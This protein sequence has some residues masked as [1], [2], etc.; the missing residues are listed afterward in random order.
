MNK[1][2]GF[3]FNTENVESSEK[4]LQAAERVSD[5]TMD[6]RDVN[7]TDTPANQTRL[8]TLLA[9]Q[10]K[11]ER[12]KRKQ[13]L[14]ALSGGGNTVAGTSADKDGRL[15][16]EGKKKPERI[17]PNY[18][19]AIRV[20]NPQIH[21]GIK[22]VQDSITT[23]NKKLQ[24][25][26]IPL[27]TL[28]VTLM[29]LHLEDA[30]Q[31]Q[32]AIEVLNQC[33]TRL[34]PILNNSALTLTFSG[35]GHFGHQVLYVKLS[36]EEGM[37]VLQ[38]VENTVREIF[39]DEGI[40]S[41]DSREFNPHLTVMKLSRNPKLRRKGI[42]KIPEESYAS[43]VDMSF[44]EEPVN[45][46]HLCSMSEKD[47]DGFYKCV[48][49]VR[50]DDAANCNE[51]PPPE[52]MTTN[53]IKV[54]DDKLEDISMEQKQEMNTRTAPGDKETAAGDTGKNV[55]ENASC[56]EDLSKELVTWTVDEKME[57]TAVNKQSAELQDDS[58]RNER[59]TDPQ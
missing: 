44:G 32:K 2:S 43:W 50:F 29:V 55:L 14:H 8:E 58:D 34:E 48:A 28:H 11:E 10:R 54:Q 1:A 59:K 47:K 23:Q 13:R 41:T 46:I 12:R 9:K 42:K 22:I 37:E 20:S 5:V 6:V 56:D 51:P 36:G 4:D 40:P 35:L 57:D 17:I 18:F 39:T 24:P 25:A 45:A 7:Q 38:S 53:D 16:P 31:I 15:S 3:E 30:E 52:L 27:A 19:L 49:T 26:F 21:S 33:K